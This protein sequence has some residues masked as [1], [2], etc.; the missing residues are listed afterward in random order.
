MLTNLGRLIPRRITV[1]GFCLVVIVALV[2][3]CSPVIAALDGDEKRLVPW[4]LG[5][6]GVVIVAIIGIVLFVALF[7]NPMRLQ[8]QPVTAGDY[9]EHE[10]IKGT[11]G[12]NVRGPHQIID[13]GTPRSDAPEAGESSPR[14][15]KA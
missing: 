14:Q 3:A 10:R 4:V 13:A 7:R 5:F 1:L 9:V 6:V 8:L 12:D 11:L 2:F 15:L